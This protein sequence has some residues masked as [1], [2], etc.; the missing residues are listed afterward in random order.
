MYFTAVVN[1]IASFEFRL[2]AQDDKP[3]GWKEL[4]DVD[5]DD[6]AQ[7]NYDC[8]VASTTDGTACGNTYVAA[9][10]TTGNYQNRVLKMGYQKCDG[11]SAATHSTDLRLDLYYRPTT[12][13]SVSVPLPVCGSLTSVVPTAFCDRDGVSAVS[14]MVSLLVIGFV[15]TLLSF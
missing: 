7:V 13:L 1:D 2:V 8:F 14:T 10:E 5:E 9:G 4:F 11:W 3:I 12:M 15:A 6:D